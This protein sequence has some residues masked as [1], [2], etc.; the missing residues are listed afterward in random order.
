MGVIAKP[1]VYSIIAGGMW[2]KCFMDSWE[3]PYLAC[4][5]APVFFIFFHHRNGMI[6]PNWHEHILSGGGSTSGFVLDQIMVVLI[7]IYSLC[8]HTPMDRL[9]YYCNELILRN[10]PL[11][12]AS[13]VP[14][15]NRIFFCSNS[16]D[17]WLYPFVRSKHDTNLTSML[18]LRSWV[19]SPLV[20]S[21][22]HWIVLFGKID[23]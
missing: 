12:H 7:S 5:F 16:W 11:Q 19:I 20:G 4:G 21:N 13:T 3:Y 9:D 15:P 18:D 17:T 2:H 10:K 6:I 14:L 23:G 8:S 1:E 22:T